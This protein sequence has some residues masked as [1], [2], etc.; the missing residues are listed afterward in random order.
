MSSVNSVSALTSERTAVNSSGAVLPRRTMKFNT[1]AMT[2]RTTGRITRSAL[3]S[4]ISFRVMGRLGRQ[5]QICGRMVVPC[6]DGADVDRPSVAAQLD[7]R[8]R[9]VGRADRV[10]GPAGV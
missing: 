4:A 2:P 8:E 7:E 9:G 3:M 6:R 1:A 10:S 5:Q